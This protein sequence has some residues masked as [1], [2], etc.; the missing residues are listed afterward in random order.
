V[1]EASSFVIPIA[2]TMKDD[3]DYLR[4]WSKGRS[5]PATRNIIKKSIKRVKRDVAL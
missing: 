5:V 3:I 2:K 1:S 4:K